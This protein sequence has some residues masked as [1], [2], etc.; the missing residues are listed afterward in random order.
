MNYNMEVRRCKSCIL[1]EVPGHVELDSNGI[2]NI[3]NGDKRT[4]NKENNSKKGCN[5]DYFK[6]KILFY[7][8]KN[9]K[10]NCVVSVSG[11]KDSIMTLYVAKKILNLNVLAI[12]I[13]NGFALPEMYDN[14]NN[15]TDILNVDMMIFKTSDM[16]DIFKKCIESKKDIYYCRVCHTLLEYYIK[17]ICVQNNINVILG[18]Y[19]KGQQYIK[20]SELFWIYEKSDYNIIELFKNDKKFSELSAIFQSPIKYMTEKFGNIVQLSPFKYMTWNE[21][22]ILNIIKEELKF[23]IPKNS[24]PDKSSNCMFNYVSQLKT[25]KQFGYAQHETELS[26]LVREGELSRQRALEIIRTPIEEENLKKPLLKLGLC[27]DDI[28]NY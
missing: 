25:M 13:D 26:D 2:C 12:F 6:E 15:A 7:D 4:I 8:K 9:S 27:I 24:W 21:N 14:L 3:C 28:L 20:N 11:G 10:Y 19:T 5:L 22:E 17:S 16:I 1:P 18:G 23:K